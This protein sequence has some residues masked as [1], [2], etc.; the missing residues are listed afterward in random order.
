MHSEPK[1]GPLLMAL[2]NRT[3][4]QI[5]QLRKNISTGARLLF[6]KIIVYFEQYAREIFHLDFLFLLFR[7]DDGTA[8]A[9]LKGSCFC[10][11]T[12]TS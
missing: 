7:F 12:T 1:M 6:E 5:V 10:S 3:K 8:A 11:P 9:I 4:S 2:A